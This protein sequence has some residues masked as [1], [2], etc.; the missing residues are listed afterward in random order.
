M[1]GLTGICLYNRI[2]LVTQI[3]DNE[4]PHHGIVFNDEDA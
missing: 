2:A 1:Y 3:P 4:K